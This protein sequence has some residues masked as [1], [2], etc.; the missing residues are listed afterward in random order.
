MNSK[1]EIKEDEK[2]SQN[3]TKHAHTEQTV[4]AYAALPVDGGWGWV[5]VAASFFC[6]LMVDGYTYSVG[7]FLGKIAESLHASKA[8]TAFMGSLLSGFCLMSGK[9]QRHTRIST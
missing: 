9:C 2:P 4:L 1:G 7:V 5:V 8:K 3:G 6:N